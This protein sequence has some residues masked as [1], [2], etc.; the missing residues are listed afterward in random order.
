MFEAERFSTTLGHAQLNDR[1]DGK[2][3]WLFSGLFLMYLIKAEC[4]AH[5]GF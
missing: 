4:T 1:V 3:I 5:F 2:W